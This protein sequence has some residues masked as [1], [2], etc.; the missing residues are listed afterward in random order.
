M[1]FA[2][3]HDFGSAPVRQFIAYARG[4]RYDAGH[5]LPS[6]LNEASG[7]S[8][9]AMLDGSQPDTLTYSAR[10]ADGAGLD[11]YRIRYRMMR[12]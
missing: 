1:V 7:D 6:P 3:A 5:A 11:L 12:P 9:G 8:Y 10:R 4:G 2:R